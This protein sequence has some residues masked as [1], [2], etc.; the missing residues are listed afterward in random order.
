MLWIAALLV[1]LTGVAHSWL[2]ERMLIGPILAYENHSAP[3]LQRRFARNLLRA[4]WHITTVTW[5]G[6]SAALVFLGTEPLTASGRNAV[7]SIGVAFLVM[8]IAAL[9][10]SKGRHLAWTAFL[11]TAGL[12]FAAASIA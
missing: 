10:L 3:V 4:A 6:V 8:G 11:A 2:G 9:Y 12:C 1:A 7:L 5:F